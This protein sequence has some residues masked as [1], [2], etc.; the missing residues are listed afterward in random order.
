MFSCTHVQKS[1]AK[2]NAS[3]KKNKEE[4]KEGPALT[5][6]LRLYLELM[7]DAGNLLS[8]YLQGN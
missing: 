6:L 5:H 2:I 3:L 8:T 1:R 4:K 7:K